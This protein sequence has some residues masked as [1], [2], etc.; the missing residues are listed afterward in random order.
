MIEFL[1]DIKL[2][3]NAFKEAQFFYP[4]RVCEL[5]STRIDI[6][7]VKVF[8]FFTQLIQDNLKADLPMYLS[9]TVGEFTEVLKLQNGES[10]AAL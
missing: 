3:L 5:K 10:Q 6:E 8:P 9:K 1:D 7:D 4:A 2:T